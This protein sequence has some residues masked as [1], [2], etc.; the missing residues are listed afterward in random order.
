MSNESYEVIIV[1]GGIGGLNLAALL[2]H[3]GKKVLVLERGG[4]ES[5]GGRAASGKKDG[6]AVD[7]GIKGLILAGFQDEIHQR[8]GK[9]MP[10]NV[11]EWTNSGEIYVNGNWRNVDEMIRSSVGEFMK[12]FEGRPREEAMA[13]YLKFRDGPVWANWRQETIRELRELLSERCR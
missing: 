3:A 7:N 13:D 8:I 1:G 12:I 4:E 10:E 2:T 5:L 11:S 9:N 6:A